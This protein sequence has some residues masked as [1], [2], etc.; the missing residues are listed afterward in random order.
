MKYLQMAVIYSKQHITRC[1]KIRKVAGSAK[2]HSPA[3]LQCNSSISL[4]VMIAS[5]KYRAKN[6]YE[7][8]TDIGTINTIKPIGVK[9]LPEPRIEPGTT[10]YQH[11]FAT[12]WY[13][14]V[15]GSILDSG[16]F[17]SS[18]KVIVFIICLSA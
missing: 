13:A 8:C 15:P 9:N 17:F 4:D 7:F 10:V 12:V 2:Y 16:Y 3:E 18:V 11:S 1:F 14:A 5:K 6:I